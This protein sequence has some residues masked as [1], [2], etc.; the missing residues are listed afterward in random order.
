MQFSTFAISVVLR[1]L[2]FLRKN[3]NERTWT[4][5]SVSAR[6]RQPE[7]FIILRT[8]L[9]FPISDVAELAIRFGVHVI[10]TTRADYDGSP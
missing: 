7:R 9:D 1:F 2:H 4:K 8:V 6:R 3:D 10:R 5:R